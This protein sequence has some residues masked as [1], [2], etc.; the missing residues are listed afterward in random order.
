MAACSTVVVQRREGWAIVRIDR[1]AKRNALDRATRAGL[2]DAFSALHG[3]A[4]VIVLTGTGPSFCAGLD[5]TERSAELAAGHPD[6]AGTEAIELN[7]AIREHPAIV[8]AAVNGLALGGGVTLVN[9]SDLALAAEDAALGAPEIGFARYASM[10]GPTAQ[11]LVNRKRA[12][13]FLLANQ[14]IDAA[15]A[16]DWGMVNEV[17]PSAA[18][19][20]RCGILAAS[21]ARADP[22]ALVEIKAALDHV[23][24]EGIGWRAALEYGQ[25][26]NAAIQAKIAA[27][28]PLA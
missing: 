14:R 22:V 17:V 8:I 5:L 21:I 20:E 1:P 6:T 11:L 9:M 24:G 18:L 7:M 10:A 19:M 27:K 13:W 12:A 25:G 23:P 28:G 4:Q 2:R 3:T 16:R 15:T 26:V